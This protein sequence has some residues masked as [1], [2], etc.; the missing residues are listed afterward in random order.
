M[1]CQHFYNHNGWNTITIDG[2]LAKYFVELHPSLIFESG[3]YPT[4]V[5]KLILSGSIVPNR[6]KRWSLIFQTDLSLIL[7][8]QIPARELFTTLVALLTHSKIFK[9]PLK[10][11][12]WN[13]DIPYSCLNSEIKQISNLVH[14]FV[15]ILKLGFTNIIKNEEHTRQKV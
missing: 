1:S 10:S 15:W 5:W 2:T 6:M 7:K 3:I 11:I 4:F 13:S 9:I 12:N 8:A 14:G